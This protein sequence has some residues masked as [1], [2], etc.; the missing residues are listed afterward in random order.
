MGIVIIGIIL[1]IALG[2]LL[3]AGFVWIICWAL[4]AMGIH[5]IAGWTVQ[6]SW[7]LVIVFTLICCLISGFFTNA[8]K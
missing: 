2:F 4:N 1:G 8:R 6:F 7:P 3:N 5:V